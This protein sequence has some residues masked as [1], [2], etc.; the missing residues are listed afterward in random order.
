[1]ECA[2][3]T[4]QMPL[5]EIFTIR[6]VEDKPSKWLALNTGFVTQGHKKD[7]RPLRE[8]EGMITPRLLLFAFFIVLVAMGLAGEIFSLRTLICSRLD[9][10]FVKKL[11]VVAATYVA[12]SWVMALLGVHLLRLHL[13][14]H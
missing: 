8:C 12:T 6:R 3:I 4:P 10:S 13:T 2:D 7:G 14:G 5:F 11:I 9:D 1:M